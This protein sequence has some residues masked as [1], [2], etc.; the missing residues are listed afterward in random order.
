MDKK[1]LND[2]V[3]YSSNEIPHFGEDL[4]TPFN[5]RV[6]AIKRMYTFLY[7]KGILKEVSFEY[8]D[9]GKEAC[10][11]LHVAKLLPYK[12]RMLNSG[13]EDAPLATETIFCEKYTPCVHC[14]SVSLSW[15]MRTYRDNSGCVGRSWECDLCQHINNKYLPPIVNERKQHSAKN[16]VGTAWNLFYRTGKRVS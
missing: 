8:K 7:K 11:A 12:E 15:T 4:S 6:A 3:V 13:V 9:D 16:A 10:F 5:K 2:Y 1:I 14:G